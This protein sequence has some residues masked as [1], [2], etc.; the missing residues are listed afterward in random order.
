[1]KGLNK[2]EELNAEEKIHGM[3]QYQVMDEGRKEVEKGS[4]AV[5]ITI[6]E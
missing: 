3:V 4:V 1:M 6:D 2:S 5:S